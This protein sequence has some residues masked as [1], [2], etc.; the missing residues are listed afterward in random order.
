[1]KQTPDFEA[2]KPVVDKAVSSLMEQTS[3]Y[4]VKL[5]PDTTSLSGVKAQPAHESAVRP[6]QRT[7]QTPSAAGFRPVHLQE[8][9]TE[10]EFQDDQRKQ[11]YGE[12]T[13]AYEYGEKAGRYI[14]ESAVSDL[15]KACLSVKNGVYSLADDNTT[16]AIIFAFENSLGLRSGAFF[17]GDF[18]REYFGKSMSERQL[19]QHIVDI[20]ADTD[21][22]DS[23]IKAKWESAKEAYIGGDKAALVALTNKAIYGNKT[24]NYRNDF[25]DS[26]FRAAQLASSEKFNMAKIFSGV[27]GEAVTR[28]AVAVSVLANADYSSED[29]FNSGL[30][31]ELTE[32]EA[33]LALKFGDELRAGYEPG[34]GT[35][36]K[37]FVQGFGY[38][39]GDTAKGIYNALT[40]SEVSKMNEIYTRFGKYE[41]VGEIIDSNDLR[42][43]MKILDVEDEHADSW[44]KLADASAVRFK[45]GGYER[46]NEKFKKAKEVANAYKR[47]QDAIK[48]I[49]SFV[50]EDKMYNYGKV[51]DYMLDAAEFTGRGAA[52]A[53]MMIGLSLATGGIGGFG[54]LSAYS[55]S[56]LNR[57]SQAVA[58][59]LPAYSNAL[60][61]YRFGDM[62]EGDAK[63]LAFGEGVVIGATEVFGAEV[64]AG[65]ALR[66]LERSAYK[67]AAK[68]VA[69]AEFAYRAAGAK[70]VAET[71]A[72]LAAAKGGARRKFVETVKDF[73][74]S[75]LTESFL[76][77][78]IQQ[79]L[80]SALRLSSD[81]WREDGLDL[82]TGKEEWNEFTDTMLQSAKFGMW[83]VLPMHLT[84]RVFGGKEGGVSRVVGV[85]P[86]ASGKVQ[87]VR[88]NVNVVDATSAEIAVQAYSDAIGQAKQ[89]GI[90]QEAINAWRPDM[91]QDERE[92]VAKQYKLTEEQTAVLDAM[93]RYLETAKDLGDETIEAERQIV[94]F[95]REI[96]KL[97]K[98]DLEEIK[99]ELANENAEPKVEA[100]PTEGSEV[101][102]DKKVQFSAG[103][104]IAP[105][106]APKSRAYIANRNKLLAHLAKKAGVK[107]IRE[108]SKSIRASA[109][110]AVDGKFNAQRAVRSSPMEE[111][112]MSMLRRDRG[113]LPV[114]YYYGRDGKVYFF[115]T[116]DTDKVYEFRP[117]FLF[118]VEGSEDILNELTYEIE[119]GSI[120]DTKG[121]LA[122]ASALRSEKGGGAF[123]R[124]HI[125][126]WRRLEDVVSGNNARVR[127]NGEVSESGERDSWGSLLGEQSGLKRLQHNGVV[128]G[129]YDPK[130][131]EL[132]L[133]EDFISFDTP[134]H[135]FTHIWWEVVRAND[136]RITDQIVSLMK[137][138]K[139]FKELKGKWL[140]D[141]N[142][143]YHGMSD[144]DIAQEC[145][146]RMVG[147][148]G[149]EIMSEEGLTLWSK[150]RKAAMDFFKN[151]L[152]T[153]G[154]TDEQIDDLSLEDLQNMCLRDLFDNETLG[155]KAMRGKISQRALLNDAI[156]NAAFDNSIEDATWKR[157]VRNASMVVAARLLM[158]HAKLSAKEVDDMRGDLI[159][160]AQKALPTET[161]DVHEAV[162]DV[163]ST[164]AKMVYSTRDTAQAAIDANSV[165]DELSFAAKSLRNE[166]ILS[167]AYKKGTISAELFAE[168]KEY[169]DRYT[170]MT[171]T[172]RG[173]KAKALSWEEV[174]AAVGGSLSEALLMYDKKGYGV[175]ITD[176]KRDTV[177]KIIA[178]AVAQKLGAD[179]KPWDVLH[180]TRLTLRN[181]YKRYAR[182]WVRGAD[183]DQA[184]RMAEDI[185]EKDSMD[186]V[187]KAAEKA[188]QILHE[189]GVKLTLNDISNEIES[190]LKK[191][192]KRK[193]GVTDPATKRKY[194]GGFIEF[195]TTINK[196]FGKMRKA[197]KDYELAIAKKKKE[198]KDDEK[199]AQNSDR[200]AQLLL[201]SD[202]IK[203]QVAEEIDSTIKQLESLEKGMA[204]E[205]MFMRFSALSAVAELDFFSIEQL[206]DFKSSLET[207][208]QGDAKKQIAERQK[209]EKRVE[210]IA[211]KLTN[212]VNEREGVKES[213][214]ED[215]KGSRMFGWV[216]RHAFNLRQR[217]EDITRYA[218]GG[219]LKSARSVT[220]LIHEQDVKANLKKEKEIHR[221]HLA[222]KEMLAKLGYNTNNK[223]RDLNKKLREPR[224]DLAKFSMTGEVGMCLDQLLNL[225]LG[226][227]QKHVS[228]R[229]LEMDAKTREA[230]L[231][232]NEQA[233]VLWRQISMM[234]EMERILKDEGVLEIGEGLCKLLAD[235]RL[236]INE[237]SAKYFGLSLMMFPEDDKY[238]PVKRYNV[239][240]N[241]NMQGSQTN[242]VPSA[243][244][245]RV[246]NN[247]PLDVGAFASS[248]F[249]NQIEETE[250]FVAYGDISRF[251]TLLFSN[252]KFK[253]SVLRKF[254]KAVLI[255]LRDAA[256]ET[257]NGKF[258]NPDATETSNFINKVTNFTSIATLGFN[259]GTMFK[260][261]SSFLTFANE[262][263]WRNTFKAL[264]FSGIEESRIDVIK[265][266]MKHPLWEARYRGAD[267][268]KFLKE[269]TTTKH[270]EQGFLKRY[271]ELSML[272]VK[273]GDMVAVAT[274]G[275]GVYAATKAEL[276]NRYNVE[277]GTIYTEQEAADLAMA[278]TMEIAD[279]TQQAGR[280]SNYNVIQR[281]FG[282]PGRMMIQFAS[283]ILQMY[284]AEGH[285]FLDAYAQ[286]WRDSDAN[287]KLATVAFNNHIVIPGLTWA[288][289]MVL[290]GLFK[291]E[292][293]DEDDLEDAVIAILT[294]PFGSMFF[295]GGLIMA[296]FT[297]RKSAYSNVAAPSL[298]FME[299]MVKGAIDI[300]AGAATLDGEQAKKGV[301]KSARSFAPGRMAVDLVD[302][303]VVDLD[304]KK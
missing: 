119:N 231:Q 61:R 205:A 202:E 264:F 6:R 284:G 217:F 67:K 100:A 175:L 115:E 98:E 201:A 276:M 12:N 144:E 18:R 11:Q 200:I 147:K 29:I 66:A 268:G 166:R 59:G 223:L 70:T 127:E 187:M 31:D 124:S 188:E 236:R 251:F 142:S 267:S 211:G 169:T 255:G 291:G 88:K 178:D 109:S 148:R 74:K 164:L 244:M 81:Y 155:I 279:Q 151:V 206:L 50:G 242:I 214:L 301:I 35:L 23:L 216:V 107:I 218:K 146:S 256:M 226:L 32:E 9:Y 210:D 3:D 261:V 150:I 64:I 52:Q 160:M 295:A 299:R 181:A 129:Y 26:E 208:E 27:Y 136:K 152:R 209:A 233:S 78:G 158:K 269:I 163:A 130:T 53:G 120:R 91:T 122:R 133:N 259:I 25:S 280:T 286:G 252:D 89:Q 197:A 117:L 195:A 229:L 281:R 260:Q 82:F 97:S 92:A 293:P 219:T 40:D 106:T 111:A 143:V 162:V 17:N 297:G 277:T 80:I 235:E 76:E 292:M 289:A 294:G 290:Q 224:E 203:K 51:F 171:E 71:T 303:W 48:T 90:S 108:N 2:N 93:N 37:R 58:F 257:A 220:K 232:K 230:Y 250:H 13:L 30:F 227:R 298:S 131:R 36:L 47:R 191:I 278:F 172:G 75:Y 273:F 149:E 10:E 15:D 20:V 62:E 153:F 238:F 296:M 184:T 161:S 116:R 185:E 180:A 103:E 16:K 104:F 85:A 156:D 5:T 110:K 55:T 77:E 254:G 193:G 79:S 304:D 213:E 73:G 112:A 265:E 83:Q 63:L 33:I 28:A 72:A 243:V 186:S 167:L 138:T 198:F 245:P 39:I 182:T 60:E 240:V 123:T 262:I 118:E 96:D 212:A 192:V 45:K 300:A 121:L 22:R 179:A 87:L 237:A 113:V 56:I 94:E 157:N 177:S 7:P 135:E 282:A 140:S 69:Q 287:K 165:V 68:T 302:T 54:N 275:A 239:G 65:R 274:V 246:T 38:E 99:A 222:T 247:R 266:M 42:D 241:A 285:A 283:S 132:H 270:G 288:I 168:A 271:A 128:Y 14:Q 170:R 102:P 137:Q 249:F 126:K 207:L 159:K 253:E 258:F 174:N 95:N 141:K 114:D 154:L 84:G 196:Y 248:A 221:R 24:E 225:Y 1:M 263:G 183:R 194:S 234:D 189:K 176:N 49:E 57:V 41:S 190:T 145:F 43:L 19:A 34:V 125:K 105:E 86:E 173:S 134:I 204:A 44:S 272:T 139:M 101:E 4:E 21:T 8:G 199:A 228:G 215:R 46:V